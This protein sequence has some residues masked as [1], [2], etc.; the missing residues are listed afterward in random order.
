MALPSPSDLEILLAKVGEMSMFL[1][2][3]NHKPSIFLGDEQYTK[4][5]SP[6][7]LHLDAHPVLIAR[8]MLMLAAALQYLSPNTTIPG[9]GEHH[10]VI[11]D[12]L[13]ESAI[14]L[15]TTN[16][17]FLGTLEGLENICLEAC[18]HSDAGNIRRAWI[19]M[20]RAVMAAQLMGLHRSGHHRFKVISNDKDLDPEELWACTVSMERI[21]S[22]LLGLPT[23]TA[24]AKLAV[25][26]TPRDASQAVNMTAFVTEVTGRILQ[27][28][29][30]SESGKS[31]EMTKEIDG[32]L[33]KV[34]EQMPSSFW[35]PTTFTGLELDSQ[36]A[37]WE[38]RRTWDLMCYFSVVT[39]LHL[40][41][42][43]CPQQ[44]SQNHYSR[45]VCVNASREIL[46]RGI[47]MRSFNPVTP[48]CR[49]GDFMA[50]IAGMTLVLAHVVTHYRT[51]SDNPLVHQRF[52]DRALVE[53]ALECM[54]S[55]TEPREDVLAAKCTQ[56]LRHLL[57]A[58]AG[59]AQS[60]QVGHVS[61]N[62]QNCEKA[63]NAF[64]I[65]VPYVGGIQISRQ[66]ITYVPTNK[67]TAAEGRL[68][69]EG[70]TIGGI[71]SMRMDTP[72]VGDNVYYNN[73]LCPGPVIVSSF[74]NTVSGPSIQQNATQVYQEASEDLFSNQEDMWPDAAAGLDDWVFQG[75]DTAF[76]DTL[77]REA[78]T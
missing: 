42:M 46:T 9:L 7:N 37:F 26:L 24:A 45:I 68:N 15:V 61:E 10:H 20:R 74:E 54:N 76:F 36:D 67:A 56:L 29:E 53:Q 66:G 73:D 63:C 23:S 71:G 27:R 48:C 52:G 72:T 39:Q 4:R 11:M 51:E 65:K 40:P 12:R 2:R 33:I 75:L 35:R 17:V 6:T 3:S 59:A 62:D 57:A 1:Y 8:D 64:I 19:T 47:A 70:V 38:I 77:M 44:V 22:L 18:Y 60:H 50:L 43:L 34:S 69:H 49:M 14:N 32:E 25:Q 30:C 41:Y 78:G 28:N 16:D 58:E 13:A 5:F 31:L 55:T 21:M